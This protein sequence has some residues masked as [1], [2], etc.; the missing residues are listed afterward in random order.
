MRNHSMNKEE[1]IEII[2]ECLFNIVEI[3][4]AY[5]YGSYALNTET[6][7]SDIDIIVYQKHDNNAYNLR[8]NEFKIESDLM[9]K[10]PGYEFDVRSFNDAP[11]IVA[12]KIFNEGRLLFYRDEKF[13]YDYLVNTRLRYMDY[14]IIY[15]PI[16]NERFQSLL[17]DR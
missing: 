1:I 8:I 4:I 15:K 7:F 16:F 17:N 6:K 5:L 11:I 14:S 9:S 10:L 2:K 13:Y 3:E 12:G